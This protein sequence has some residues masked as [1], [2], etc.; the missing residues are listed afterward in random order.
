MSLKVAFIGSHGC[1]KTTLCYELVAALKR[2]GL[3][4]DL[5]K[6]VARSCPMPVNQGTSREAQL[7]ILCTQVKE[8]LETALKSDIVVCDRSVLDNYA[9]LALQAGRD[10]ILEAFVYKWTSTYDMLIH[11]PLLEGELQPD[12]FRDTTREF[13]ERVDEIIREL[14]QNSR[15]RTVVID[16]D[17]GQVGWTDQI[18]STIH[19]KK[20]HARS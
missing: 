10:P 12:G 3:Q 15:L 8:E 14:R 17:R 11:V 9:Y 18:A 19:A 5:V 1:H 16:L 4:A 13:A 6:E 7:W 20:T 2:A